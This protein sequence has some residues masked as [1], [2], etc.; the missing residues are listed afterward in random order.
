MTKFRNSNA[1]FW[2]IFK[3]CETISTYNFQ[4]YWNSQTFHF[5]IEHQSSWNEDFSN[6]EKGDG[7]SSI[8]LDWLKCSPKW[9]WLMRT[10]LSSYLA[11]KISMYNVKKQVLH[12]H[13]ISFDKT[14][15]SRCLKITEKVS[16]N[17]TFTFWVD[18]SSVNRSKIVNFGEFLKNL[19]LAV[20]Q[21]YQTGHV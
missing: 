20:K 13:D 5:S 16:F 14:I 1:T 7:N 19:K 3:Q 4:R 11:Y 21:C 9:S 18:K 10:S 12:K 2:V 8:K 15:T 17:I 6:L